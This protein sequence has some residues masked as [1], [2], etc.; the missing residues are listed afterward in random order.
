MVD[1]SHSELQ[2]QAHVCLP[3]ELYCGAHQLPARKPAANEDF[4]RDLDNAE[5]G[6]RLAILRLERTSTLLHASQ[7]W[8]LD[9]QTILRRGRG[10]SCLDK[11]GPKNLDNDSTDG[12]SG[13]ATSGS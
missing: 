9:L 8:G 1:P 11:E 5:P 13:D 12:L 7:R 3:G 2:I 4:P 10:N 6:K